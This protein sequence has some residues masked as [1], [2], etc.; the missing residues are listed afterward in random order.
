MIAKGVQQ[1][2]RFAQPAP[3]DVRAG[4]GFMAVF[5]VLLVGCFGALALLSSGAAEP[6]VLAIMGL[7]A[8]VGVFFLFGVAAGHIRLNDG[9]AADD[10]AR[11]AVAAVEDGLVL[12]ENGG[13]VVWA[14]AAG[15]AMLGRTDTGRIHTILETFGGE[16]RSAEAV[17]RLT[18]AAE[19]GSHHVEDL[20]LPVVVGG[21]ARTTWIRV[22][23]TPSAGGSSGRSSPSVWHLTD[24]T[25]EHSRS[26]EALGEARARL[27]LY[28]G[29]PVGVFAADADGA[30]VHVN[31]T[32]LR[33]LGIS[34]GARARGLRLADLLPADTVSQ[35]WLAATDSKSLDVGFD[36][37]LVD[38]AG[39]HVP[40]TLKVVRRKAGVMG[41]AVLAIVLERG[42]GAAGSAGFQASD[43]RLARLFQ[44]APVG[45]AS[46]AADG[47]IVSSNA[48]FGRMLLSGA[49]VVGQEASQ[50]LG[51]QSEAETRAALATAVAD[52]LD[53]K[54]QSSPI[55]IA[56]GAKKEFT[57][58]VL[59]SPLG[60]AAG[61]REV[62]I[63]YVMDATEQK[64]LEVKY[65]QSQ[66]MEAVGKLA[67]GIAH[68]FNNVL[69]A[70]IGFSDLL[71]QTHR[72]SDAAYKNIMAIKS[73]ANRAAGMV[74]QLL[75]FSR[76]QTLQ[77]EVLQLGE[78]L[79]DIS[80]LLNRLLGE[81]ID[82]KISQSRDLW[83]VKADRS[84]LGQVLI[85]LA[86][87]ARDA[88]MPRGG[89]LT[90]RTRNVSERDSQRIAAQ[91][92]P[93]GQAMQVGEYV[94]IE[95]EDTG[96]GM[97]PEV[98]A[99]IFEP[100]FTTKGVGKGTGL[101][102]STVYGIVKQTGGYVFADSTLGKGTTFRVYLPRH[103]VDPAE[104]AATT[105]VVKKAPAADL[106]GTG[107]VLLVEDEDA[108]RSFAIEALK[109]QGY[110]V[111][112][113][114]TGQEG[115]EMYE[116]HAGRIDLVVSDV[117]MP[118]MDGPTLY[119]ELSKR[120]PDLKIIFMSGYPDDA[121]KNTLEE[122][123]EFAFLQKPFSLA[124][125]AGKVKEQLGR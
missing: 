108:V 33:R 98:L 103:H 112:A 97:P 44:N 61:G 109:R 8:T 78:V 59:F 52:V 100:F 89:G 96:T 16:P 87:N 5:S 53:G 86:V 91:G 13:T 66:K 93:A 105:K 63:A 67:G 40:V 90:V 92:G 37:D 69:T 64:A 54:A 125:L 62:A 113:A 118:E 6:L 34:P 57:R 79:T 4:S 26:H 12:T 24:V 39:R 76:R 99:K 94:L 23:V 123:T 28:D 70:I 49:S 25:G 120:R 81:K 2:T 45:I 27:A 15:A 36:A 3:T 14:N 84:Q 111:I 71:L 95:V 116:A 7:L 72:P 119:R 35:L 60:Q 47:S 50:L 43:V 21:Q 38:A 20:P 85:N 107:R 65:A 55:E 31:E 88:M 1:A 83:P 30:L 106:T 73:S 77:P 75:A 102:L 41:A 9:A 10:L 58:R 42:A 32:L 22:R 11:R 122:G 82:L 29:L 56:A 124:Q 18:R 19:A 74:S 115:L 17:F 80:V 117:I 110:E 51:G 121:F 104:L 46:I 68:D 101:G 48:A 114:S